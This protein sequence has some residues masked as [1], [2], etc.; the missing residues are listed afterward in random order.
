VKLEKWALIAEIVGGIAIVVSLIFVGYQVRQNTQ[1][2]QVAAY[3]QLISGISEFN[4]Q[5]LA[6]PGLRAVRI[7]LNSGTRIEELNPDEQQI[8][9]AFLYL[10]YRNGDM[11]YMQYRNGMI[12]ED[13]LISGLGILVNFLELPTVQRHWEQRKSGFV[14]E[15]RA[16]IDELIE[17][18]RNQ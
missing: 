2:T 7:K 5:T 1:V 3:Q 4:T 10:A 15:Y 14:V 18:A 17:Q 9:N 11:A 12:D 8:I 13:R 6:N 16:Y